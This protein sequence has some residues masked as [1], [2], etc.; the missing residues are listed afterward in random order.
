MRKVA[1]NNDYFA[2]LETAQRLDLLRHLIENSEIVPLVRGPTGIGKTVLALRLKQLA[3]ANWSVCSFEADASMSPEHLLVSMARCIGWS[4]IKGDQLEGLVE[5]FGLMRERGHIPVLLVDDAQFLP[6][7]SLI[8]LLRLYERQRAG[9]PLISLV[10]FADE[11][12]DVLLSTPQ[13]QIMSPQAIQTIGLPL[14]N[15]KDTT[16]YMHYLL[17]VEGLPADLELEDAR[18][19]K[20]FRETKGNPG[21]LRQ[22]ILHAIRDEDKRSG[23][24][25]TGSYLPMVIGASLSLLLIFGLLLFQDEINRL[26]QSPEPTPIEATAEPMQLQQQEVEIDPIQ[27]DVMQGLN[28]NEESAQEEEPTAIAEPVG[29]EE[30]AAVPFEQPLLLADSSNNGVDEVAQ[31]DDIN[32]QATE[33]PASEVV[34]TPSE[35]T[36]DMVEAKPEILIETPQDSVVLDASMVDEAVVVEP[37]IQAHMDLLRRDDWVLTRPA[38][39]YTVQLLGVEKL[40]SLKAFIERHHLR[41]KAFYIETERNGK[42]WYPLLWGEYPDK[43]SAIESSHQLPLE[44]QSKGTWVRSFG[45]LQ[46]LLEK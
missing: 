13:L 35:E 40:Q 30:S 7:A 6:P 4:D 36:P 11:R 27:A 34:H 33:F 32:V 24:W 45:A 25:I 9:E 38:V 22:A 8:T 18:L 31:E 10:L 2:T 14:F 37:K 20:L 19:T 41:D 17:Q 26:F 12:I 3:P 46:D 1:I 28:Q 5:R 43:P 23:T 29:L 15:R 44:V 42:S 39:H 16:T 21:L